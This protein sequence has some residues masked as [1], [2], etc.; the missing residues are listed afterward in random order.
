MKMP[1]SNLFRLRLVRTFSWEILSG[2]KKLTE[3][4]SQEG[5][6]LTPCP[7]PDKIFFWQGST[8]GL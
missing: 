3:L 6:S 4:L 1:V 5:V 2:I 7:T 8:A